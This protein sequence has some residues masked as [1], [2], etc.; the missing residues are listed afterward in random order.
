MHCEYLFHMPG[1]KYLRDSAT[2]ENTT[3]FYNSSLCAVHARIA[4]VHADII[5]HYH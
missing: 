1:H 4:S 2:S 5:I 3:R